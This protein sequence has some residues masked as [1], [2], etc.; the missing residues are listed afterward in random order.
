LKR[1]VAREPRNLYA[2]IRGTRLIVSRAKLPGRCLYL[3]ARDA[4]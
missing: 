2:A 3:D 4:A 1:V